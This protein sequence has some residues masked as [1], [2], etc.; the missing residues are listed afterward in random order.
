MDPIKEINELCKEKGLWLHVDGAYGAFAAALPEADP[1]LKALAV[2]DSVALDPHK[3]LY[4]PME[5]GCAL[6][7]D[8]Q[9]LYDA[10][11]FRPPY[12]RFDEHK[13]GDWVNFF[14]LGIQNSRG[15]R[16][17]KVWLA[18]QQVGRRGYVESIRQDIALAKAMGEAAQQA[19]DIEFRSQR[20]SIVVYRYVPTDLQPDESTKTY[21]SELNE[22]ILRRMQAGGEVFV[23]NA[24]SDGDYLLRAC[25]VNFRTQLSDALAAITVAQR[26]GQEIDREMRPA[27]LR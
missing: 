22:E 27:A 14:E 13:S 2:A 4:A 21:L 25:V 8:R 5:A 6:V 26:L 3:W 17:L 18:L 12:Y 24:V 20:L 7:R 23:S 10:F 1:D 11:L 15:F 19:Q 9:L 16:A